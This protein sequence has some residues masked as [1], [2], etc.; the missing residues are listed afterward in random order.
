MPNL[1]PLAYS[2]WAVGGVVRKFVFS[3][4]RYEMSKL[5]NS[6]SSQVIHLT[7]SFVALLMQICSFFDL[8]NLRQ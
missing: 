8:R 5:A 3:R 4:R 1:G 2:V 6:H 7:D